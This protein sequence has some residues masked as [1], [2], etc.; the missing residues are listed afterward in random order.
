MALNA[1]NTLLIMASAKL[2]CLQRLKSLMGINLI[3]GVNRDIGCFDRRI[4]APE[5]RRCS[6]EVSVLLWAARGRKRPRPG[7]IARPG[8]GRA[9][10]PPGRRLGPFGSRPLPQ[11]HDR[12]DDARNGE[13]S[14]PNHC[15][16]KR[17]IYRG[18]NDFRPD[19]FERAAVLGAVKA[20]AL[21]VA[22]KAASLD[23]SC[24]RLPGTTAGRG[25]E[26]GFRS[27]RETGDRSKATRRLRDCSAQSP[28]CSRQHRHRIVAARGDMP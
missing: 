16:Q 18:H 7:A 6:S 3:L 5:R 17:S 10:E 4:V 23:S 25:G 15:G 14:R 20:E 8:V 11:D 9:T 2:A 21:R 13:Q 26:T 19:R 22:A 1:A 12:T 27:N 28:V 24:A